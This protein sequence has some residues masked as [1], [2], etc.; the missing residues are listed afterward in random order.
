MSVLLGEAVQD[1][2]RLPVSRPKTHTLGVSVIV[3]DPTGRALISK[4]AGSGI[5]NLPGG[6]VEPQETVSKAA[7]REV[8]EETGLEIKLGLLFAICEKPAW[9]D[10][11]FVFFAS[12]V[13][14][15]LTASDEATEH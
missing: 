10:T 5:W 7:I 1:Q 8:W 6:A 12:V 3:R 4:R 2:S 15:E 9:D 14:G 11:I 13:G